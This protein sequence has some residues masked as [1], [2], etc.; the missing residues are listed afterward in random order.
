MAAFKTNETAFEISEK[1]RALRSISERWHGDLGAYLEEIARS[2]PAAAL[3]EDVC[4][5]SA[6]PLV[7]M[8]THRKR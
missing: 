4:P 7:R 2:K 1:E 5:I 3:E 6:E 8:Q